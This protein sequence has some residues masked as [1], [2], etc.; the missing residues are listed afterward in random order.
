MGLL[1]GFFKHPDCISKAVG[2]T[3]AREA[4]HRCISLKV[5]R[6]IEFLRGMGWHGMHGV[7]QVAVVR[8]FGRVFV[9]LVRKGN[10]K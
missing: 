2:K 8:M 5:K 1:R 10:Q 4:Y 3:I 6:N 7:D 9:V